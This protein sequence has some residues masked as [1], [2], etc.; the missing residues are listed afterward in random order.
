MTVG[1]SR[2]PYRCYAKVFTTWSPDEQL[3]RLGRLVW[4]RRGGPGLAG[5][6]SAK[7][8]LGLTPKLVSFNRGWREWFI[9]LFGIRV[10]Y[11]RAFGGWIV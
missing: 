4:S 6:W 2:V 9:V 10:H 1:K 5:G 8:S 3:L 7:L 11:Q